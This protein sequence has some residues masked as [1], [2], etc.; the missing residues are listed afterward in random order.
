MT[1]GNAFGWIFTEMGRQPWIVFQSRLMTTLQRRLAG[2][3]APGGV[4]CSII[5]LTLLYGVLAVVEIWLILRF[6]KRGADRSRA[7]RTVATVTTTTDRFRVRVLRGRR[8]GALHRLVH[9]DRR[10]LDP[11]FTLEGSTSASACCCRSSPRT[12]SSAGSRSTPSARSGTATRSGSSPPAARRSRRSRSGTPRCSRVLTCPAAHPAGAHRPRPGLRVPP[13]APR[14]QLARVVG[15]RDHHRLPTCR[16]CCGASRSPTSCAGAD[17]DADKGV[18]RQPVHAAQPVRP[19]RWRSSPLLLFLTHGA[20][21]LALKTDG[22]LRDALAG[23]E[24]QAGPRRRPSPPVVFMVGRRSDRHGG[25]WCSSSVA[26]LCLVGAIAICAEGPRGWAFI[27]GGRS[28]RSPSPVAGLFVAL[29]PD[30]LRRR[31]GRCVFR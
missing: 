22:D 3:S 6:A 27:R 24:H 12:T 29:F 23:P 30:V 17:H 8:H 16:P 15:P 14:G 4:G 19:A 11:G 31:P 20:M 21:F 7:L 1:L 10:P 26:A 13:P 25:T 5:T 9:P 18:H 2:V 28:R